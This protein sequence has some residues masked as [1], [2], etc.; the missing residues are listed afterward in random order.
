MIKRLNGDTA[1]ESDNCKQA[2]IEMH[3]SKTLLAFLAEKFASELKW[4]ISGGLYTV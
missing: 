4:N 2:I 1:D 3:H